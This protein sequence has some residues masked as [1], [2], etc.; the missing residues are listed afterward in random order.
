MNCAEFQ[1]VLPYI[2]ETGGKAEEEAHLKSCPVCS[3][4]VADLRYIAEQA[5]LLVPMMDPNPRVWTGIRGALEREGLVRPPAGT[6]RFRPQAAVL[7]SRRWATVAGLPAAAAILLVA[8]SMLWLRN[9][10]VRQAQ[11]TAAATVAATAPAPAAD[12]DD[13]VLLQTVQQ[14]AP[15][16]LASY[17]EN[18]D[19]VNAYIRDAKQTLEQNPN[20]VGVRDHLIR[21]YD[22]K[23]LLYQMALSRSLQ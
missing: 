1:K 15:A 19:S 22:Q 17:R 21:A 6:V 14:R 9:G 13:A 23:A 16:M 10:G 8:V 18:L 5:K 12:A 3:D 11:P 4:L 7:S 20:D 2:I